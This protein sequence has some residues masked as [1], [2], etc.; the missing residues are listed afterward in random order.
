[1][2]PDVVERLFAEAERAA[3]CAEIYTEHRTLEDQIKLWDESGLM[4]LLL[5]LSGVRG[6]LGLLVCCV[7]LPVLVCERSIDVTM[8]AA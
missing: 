4:R 6:W 8:R 7:A 5:S 3:V 2:L 1:V